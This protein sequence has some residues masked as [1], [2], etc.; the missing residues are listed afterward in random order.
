MWSPFNKVK[1]SAIV[2]VDYKPTIS[3]DTNLINLNEQFKGEV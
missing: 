2:E 1:E 3:G